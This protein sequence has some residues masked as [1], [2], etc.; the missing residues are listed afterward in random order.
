MKREREMQ[1]SRELWHLKCLELRTTSGRSVGNTTGI[2]RLFGES[3]PSILLEESSSGASGSRGC[4]GCCPDLQ[5]HELSHEH[6][7]KGAANELFLQQLFFVLPFS[8]QQSVDSC[9]EQLQDCFRPC[10]AQ[11]SQFVARASVAQPQAVEGMAGSA[12]ITTVSHT[13]AL[14]AFCCTR[15]ANIIDSE[16]DNAQRKH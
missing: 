13:M 2:E 15:L 8:E 10:L 14:A 9:T 3:A 16:F 1:H 7:S 12:N 5:E 11:H 6:S 4:I